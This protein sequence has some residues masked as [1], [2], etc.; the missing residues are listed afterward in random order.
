MTYLLFASN[1]TILSSWQTVCICFFLFVRNHSK[2]RWIHLRRQRYIRMKGE[3]KQPEVLLRL[4]YFFLCFFS[5]IGWKVIKSVTV[6][7]ALLLIDLWELILHATGIWVYNGKQRWDVVIKQIKLLAL[8]SVMERHNCSGRLLVWLSYSIKMLTRLRYIPYSIE[9]CLFYNNF[10][11][12]QWEEDLE[13]YTWCLNSF[14][15]Y[16]WTCN[17]ALDSSSLNQPTN[18]KS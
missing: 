4:V 17:W 11:F 15:F 7:N 8:V 10:L 1:G 12:Q 13:H 16:V 6:Q 5:I 14:F 2:K 9:I 3:R 18:P